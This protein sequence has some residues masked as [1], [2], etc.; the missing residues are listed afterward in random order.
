MKKIYTVLSA[1]LIIALLLVGLL[2]LLALDKKEQSPSASLESFLNGNYGAQLLDFYGRAFPQPE[3]L[4]QTNVKLN[5]FYKYSGLSE[6][7]SPMVI[8]SGKN[9]AADGGSALA[10][11]P[12]DEPNPTGGT[13]TPAQAE[14]TQTQIQT[15]PANVVEEQLGDTMLIG[16]RAVEVPYRSE[17][18]LRDYAAAIDGIADAL[19]SNVRV[20]SLLVPNSAEFY[21]S[22]A[23]HSGESSQQKMIADCYAK[24][25]NQ[26][27]TVDAYSEISKHVGEYIYF[28]TDHHWTQLGAYY[29][30]YAFCNSAGFT[31]VPLSRFETGSY[32]GFVGSM[33]NVLEAYPQASVLKDH[34]DT[35][36]FYR[37]FVDLNTN[38]YE[39]ASMSTAIP[40]GTLCKVNETPNKYLCFLGGDHPITTIETDAKGP[41]C[42]LIKESY[43]NAFA[44]WLTS[45]YSKIIAVDP[46]EFNRDGKPSLDL[47]ALASAL[48]VSD[49]II[50]NYPMMLN[51]PTYIQWLE[52]L[53]K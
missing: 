11:D 7:D 3:G 4:S 5:G 14:P 45:H 39:D 24:M 46:R 41:V 15:P 49:C 33:Y 52:M 29:A 22:E 6:E 16:D 44:P 34:P 53:I 2:S 28:R 42:M 21:T 37:P 8:V 26:V 9:T 27:S 50:L 25:G 43:G 10:S 38:F 35:V 17:E 30:Y 19:G 23:Y 20:F 48:D 51:S 40:T 47:A 13:D 12:S 18:A 36:N 31:P 1:A 32:E